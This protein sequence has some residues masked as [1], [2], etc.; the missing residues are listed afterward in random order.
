MGEAAFEVA[1]VSAWHRA[2]QRGLD[3][4][5]E[6]AIRGAGLGQTLEGGSRAAQTVADPGVPFAG[7]A[8]GGAF[9]IERPADGVPFLDHGNEL[10]AKRFLGRV[11]LGVAVVAVAEQVVMLEQDLAAM[12]ARWVESARQHANGWSRIP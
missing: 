5:R 4:Q 6:I 3:A 11:R 9:G 1:E 8:A 12:P 10:V 2:Q 7:A